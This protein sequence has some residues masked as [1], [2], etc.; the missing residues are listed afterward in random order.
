MFTEIVEA[1]L[2]DLFRLALVLGLIY[3]MQRTREVTG[4]WVPL[5]AG[6]VFVA[7]VIPMTMP[8]T[9]AAPFWM[10]VAAGLVS[11]SMLAAAGLAVWRA[12]S[13]LKG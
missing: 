12:F 6:I 10:Q 1:Q 7:V 5:A 13:R 2:T 9:I 3:T 4:T 8:A 11:N